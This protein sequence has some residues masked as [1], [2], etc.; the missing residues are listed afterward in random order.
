MVKSSFLEIRTNPCISHQVAD[1]T[2]APGKLNHYRVQIIILRTNLT[3]LC[4]S[5]RGLENGREKVWSVD[6]QIYSG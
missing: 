3:F 4:R 6:F 1:L 5:S 2:A